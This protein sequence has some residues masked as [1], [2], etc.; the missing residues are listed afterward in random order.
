MGVVAPGE[1]EEEE[2]EVVYMETQLLNPYYMFRRSPSI[3]RDYTHQN[4]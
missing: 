4:I 1:D 3:S 2:E